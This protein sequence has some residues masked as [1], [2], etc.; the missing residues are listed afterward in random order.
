VLAASSLTVSPAR[1]GAA[2]RLEVAA[3]AAAKERKALRELRIA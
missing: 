3:A 2:K 1:T